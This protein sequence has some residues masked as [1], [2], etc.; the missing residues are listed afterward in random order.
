MCQVPNAKEETRYPIN[1]IN[2]QLKVK[3]SKFSC[4]ILLFQHETVSILSSNK[5]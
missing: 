4:E 2:E 3:T 5:I 1:D